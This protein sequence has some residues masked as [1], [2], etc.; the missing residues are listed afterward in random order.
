MMM[1]R[2]RKTNGTQ[3][4]VQRLDPQF[5]MKTF[6][7]SLLATV[8]L[9][10]FPACETTTTT[11]TTEETLTRAPSEAVTETRTIRTY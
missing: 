4:A 7:V 3:S 1:T 5:L 2:R 8:V 11:T 6:A 10:I 9:V